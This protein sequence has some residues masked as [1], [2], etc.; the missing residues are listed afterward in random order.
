MDNLIFLLY[1]KDQGASRDFYSAFFGSLPT[2]DVP[3]MT[4][5]ELLPKVRV[6]MMPESGISKL[7]TP[8]LPAPST[9]SGVPRCELYLRV[10][11]AQ[12]WVERGLAAG[13]TLVRATARMDW[14]E[15]VTYL[16]DGDGHVIAVAE[17]DNGLVYMKK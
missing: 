16:A 17:M 2:L 12:A 5:F 11:N 15:V 1:V 7:I 13:A 8:P 3:G 9:A 10:S 6:G 4:E 14:G